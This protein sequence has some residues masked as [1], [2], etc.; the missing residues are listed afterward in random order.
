MDK[1]ESKENEGESGGIVMNKPFY[2]KD[3]KWAY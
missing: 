3:G 2:S 1:F